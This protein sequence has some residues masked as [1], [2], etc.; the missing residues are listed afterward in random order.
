MPP[1]GN[2]AL[3]AITLEEAYHYCERLTGTHYENFSIGTRLIPKEKRRHIYAIYAYCRFVDDLGD[4]SKPD[5]NPGPG[6][7]DDLGQVAAHRL[8]LLDWWQAELGACYAGTPT[9]PVTVALQETIQTFQIPPEPFLKLIEANRRDQ[10]NPRHPTYAD[11][12]YYC[13]RSANPVGHLFL[14]LFGYQDVERQ[15]LADCT[16]TALQLTNFWQ[17]VARDYQKGRIYIPE[18]DLAR[19]EYTEHDLAQR[20]ATDN[21]RD[22]LAFEVERAMV[23]FREGAPLVAMLDGPVKLDVALF[24]RGG[25]AVLEAIKRQNYD[26]LTTRPTLSRPTKAGLFISSWFTWKLGLGF[27]LPKQNGKAKQSRYVT[28]ASKQ[29]GSP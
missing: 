3:T 10:R 22:L 29:C 12:L 26:V 9:H 1:V 6:S 25:V 8:A 23:L 4:E 21:F 13:D 27:G 28:D 17:D 15:Q 24:T 5:N 11:L 14:Y 7:S 16:C 18:E 20:R 2:P 19:F